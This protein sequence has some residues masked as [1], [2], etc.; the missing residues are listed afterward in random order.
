[1]KTRTAF[2]A[3]TLVCAGSL[4]GFELKSVLAAG[5]PTNNPLYYS[6][7][8]TEAGQPVNATRA[9]TVNLWL[10]PSP[11]V[12][13]TALCVTNVASMPV[14]S[15]RF[16]IALDSNCVAAIHANPDAYVEVIDSGTTLGRMKIGAVPY[17]AE[18]DHAVNATNAT[19]AAAGGALATALSTL[20]GQT[21][22]ASGFEA[23]RTTAQVVASKTSTTLVF[24]QIKLDLAS[25]YTNT[26]GVFKPKAAGTYVVHCAFWTTATNAGTQWNVSIYDGSTEIGGHDV[27]N[28]TAGDGISSSVTAIASLAAGDSVTCAAY[29][30]GLSASI[31]GQG[32]PARTAFSAARLY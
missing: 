5:I 13:E 22:S 6:G 1:M 26:T 23:F 7:T 18:A 31:G 10:N 2:V 12:G 32:F 16:R 11:V 29:Q 4:A 9:I 25:E 14:V 30:D 3:A 8:L 27:Q 15:G 21:H 19:N 20:E 17:A 28:A 24:D